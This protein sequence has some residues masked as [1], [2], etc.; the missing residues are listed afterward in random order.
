MSCVIIQ[1]VIFEF[2]SNRAISYVHISMAVWFSSCTKTWLSLHTKYTFNSWCTR[3]SS[4]PAPATCFSSH[5]W[6]VSY[7][8]GYIYNLHSRSSVIV[9]VRSVQC[10]NASYYQ[11]LMGVTVWNS[12]LC[13][14]IQDDLSDQIV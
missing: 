10:V 4:Y 11:A 13:I 14:K 12:N 1:N 3:L 8:S 9:I 5:F 7:G 2:N 6:G